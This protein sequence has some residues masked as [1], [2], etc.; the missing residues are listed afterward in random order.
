MKV[1]S[2]T[3][4]HFK[5]F[6]EP[7]RIV[8]GDDVTCLAGENESSRMTILKLLCQLDP[9]NGD[10]KTFDIRTEY[11]RWHLARDGRTRDRSA[12]SPVQLN[13]FRQ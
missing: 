2:A 7:H 3:I 6:F 8:V 1:I 12:V 9:A 4:G 13:S 10:G 5:N 11:P